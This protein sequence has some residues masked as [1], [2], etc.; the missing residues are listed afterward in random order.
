[1]ETINHLQPTHILDLFAGAGNLSLPLVKN[2][3]AA[4]LIES[5]SSSCADARDTVKRESL[6]AKIIQK[7]AYQ[8]TAGQTFFDVVLL[9]PPRKGTLHVLPQILMTMPKAIIY[10]SCNPFALAK[11]IKP[12]IQAGYKIQKLMVFDMFPQTDHVEVFCLLSKQ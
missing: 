7:N 11:D 1:M 2:G 6:Q 8:Y 3:F 5:A 9:D 10:V 12:A 4:T